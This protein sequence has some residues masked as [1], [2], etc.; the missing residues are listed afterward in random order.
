MGAIEYTEKHASGALNRVQGMDFK[1][2]LNPYQGCAHDCHYCFARRY[3]YLMDLNPDSDFSGSVLI[4]TNLPELLTRQVSSPSW[5]RETIAIGTSTDPY[6]PIEGKYR[7]TRRCLE[8][9]AVRKNPMFLVTKGTLALRDADLLAQ[10]TREA[11]GAVCFSITTMD[12]KIWRKLE[13]GTPPPR[14]RLQ[15]LEKLVKSGVNA[16]VLVAPIVPGVTDDEAGL[17]EVVRQ[18][19]EHGARFLS[20]SILHLKEGTKGHFFNFLKANYPRLVMPYRGL[21][22]G[23]YPPRRMKEQVWNTINELKSTYDLQDRPPRSAAPPP[24]YQYQM[25]L[26]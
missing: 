26:A 10:L 3:H 4:K 12:E 20:G 18:A 15:V 23:A 16:G 5:K 24:T 17:S 21:Y 11:E 14:K 7:L 9:L 6:Q 2:S 22:P 13:P 1:W 8:V 25:A 19:S